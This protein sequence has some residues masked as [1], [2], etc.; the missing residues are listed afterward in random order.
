MI[1]SEIGRNP[2]ALFEISAKLIYEREDTLFCPAW[3]SFNKFNLNYLRSHSKARDFDAMF[4]NPTSK[5][6]RYLGA[7]ILVKGSIPLVEIRRIYF[8]DEVFFERIFQECK[9]IIA[10]RPRLGII[11]Y[12][13]FDPEKFK[14]PPD[15]FLKR[16]K[17]RGDDC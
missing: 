14:R 12:F 15:Y 13:V 6:P 2:L 16:S 4:P 1:E 7:E 8:S 5:E 10:T 11:I 17:F 9:D 3:L